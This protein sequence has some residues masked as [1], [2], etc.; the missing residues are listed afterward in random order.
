MAGVVSTVFLNTKST[1]EADRCTE[2]SLS[3]ISIGEKYVQ[4]L[5]TTN[6]IMKIMFSGAQVPKPAASFTSRCPSAPYYSS[7]YS[8]T[9]HIT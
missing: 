1:S 3:P 8:S 6:G 2:R 9:S 7:S 4:L 5:Y